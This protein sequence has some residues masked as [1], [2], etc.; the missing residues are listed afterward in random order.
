MT[1]DSL[2]LEL[3]NAY[4]D[5]I[6]IT[7]TKTFMTFYADDYIKNKLHSDTSILKRPSWKDS[8]FIRSLSTAANKDY[9]KAF[10]ALHPVVIESK[11][12]L[13][14]VEKWIVE[15]DKLNNSD[16]SDNY[17]NPTYDVVINKAYANFYYSF[18]I[19]LDT[20]GNMHYGRPLVGFT[21]KIFEERYSHQCTAVMNGYMKHYLKFIPGNTLD[22]PHTSEINVHVTGNT[23][24]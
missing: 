18:T 13:V 10:A 16:L 21:D 17:M 7:G 5:T 4:A 19:F 8:L 3:L 6:D 22:I 20:A 9:H 24:R 23:K 14:K 15:R 11:S 2:K 1:R 12:P